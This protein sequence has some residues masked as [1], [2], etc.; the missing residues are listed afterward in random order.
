MAYKG[1]VRVRMGRNW[2]EVTEQ[3]RPLTKRER[4]RFQ[5]G[6]VALH[7]VN[8]VREIASQDGNKL[9]L[10]DVSPELLKK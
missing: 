1:S 6:S 7:N 3:V 4:D 9:F 5:L 8:A 2:V 10:E